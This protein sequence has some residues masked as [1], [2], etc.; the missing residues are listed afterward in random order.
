MT[1]EFQRCGWQRESSLIFGIGISAG[2]NLRG[3]RGAYSGVGITIGL[4]F[5]AV[6][7]RF[8]EK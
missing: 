2:K 7:I 5:F 4:W 8:G 3:K 1:I 6:R